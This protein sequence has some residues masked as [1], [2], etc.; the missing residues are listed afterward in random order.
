MTPLMGAAQRG[1]N[2]E[3]R[4]LVEHG[5]R[6]EARDKGTYCGDARRACAGP[7]MLA[8]NFAKGVAVTVEAPVNR[9]ET[10]ALIKELMIERGIPIP[11]GD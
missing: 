7:G 8:L 5:A 1:A 9:P 6:L 4:V 10:V 2:E 3:I 11:E